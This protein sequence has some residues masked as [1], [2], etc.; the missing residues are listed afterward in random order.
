MSGFSELAQEYLPKPYYIVI[1][2]TLAAFGALYAPEQIPLEEILVDRRY[3]YVLI[4]SIYLLALLLVR[5]YTLPAP[6]S[7][8]E[9]GIVVARLDNDPKRTVQRR[10]RNILRTVSIEEKE[11][12][13]ESVKVKDLA[14]SVAGKEDATQTAKR[15]RA[16]VLI[17]G[18]GPVVVEESSV[19]LNMWIDGAGINR[20]SILVDTSVVAE[21]GNFRQTVEE[22]SKITQRSKSAAN[23]ADATHTTTQAA[24]TSV[25]NEV[26]VKP[27]RVGAVLVGVGHATGE[28]NADA[29]ANDVKAVEDTL[30]FRYG[31]I[32]AKT[33]VN[34]AVSDQTIREAF[35]DIVNHMT[36]DDL[37]IIYFS[38]NTRRNR[39]GE[40]FFILSDQSEVMIDV[41]LNEAIAQHDRT[42]LVV[43]GGYFP[44]VHQ[45]PYSL[46]TV[47]GAGMADGWVREIQADGKV[48]GAFTFEFVHALRQV[49]TDV[50]IHAKSLFEIIEPRMASPGQ[51]GTPFIWTRNNPL[52]L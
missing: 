39:M 23:I 32:S 35:Q 26:L 49:P 31:E 43:D 15:L 4:T 11:G 37:L 36:V 25:I 27:R 28:K 44:I 12:Y 34:E 50:G 8:D 20:N 19:Y 40:S 7:D 42:L 33:I 10:L 52:T 51:L 48:M 21:L 30:R 24:A 18:A 13:T 6:F 1:A 3:W 14:R 46:A 45:S 41:Y 29:P 5:Q 9:M 16:K 47:L 22:Q 2:L 17:W 38:G